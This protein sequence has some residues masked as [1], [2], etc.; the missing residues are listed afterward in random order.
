M[1]HLP[2]SLF[3]LLCVL[4]LAVLPLRADILKGR[5]VDAETKEPLPEASLKL[6][7]TIDYNGRTATMV[8]HSTA[9][10]LGCFHL[11][12]RGRGMLEASMLGYY[13][14][15]KTVLGFSED[16]KDTV[17]VGDIELKPSETL[18]K[19]L[20]VKGRARRFTVRGDTIVFN[21]EAFH[22]QEGAR[23]DELI[24]QLPGVEVAEDGT[25]TWNGKPIRI[26]MD[27]E[28]LFGGDDIV[29]QLPAEAVESIKAYNKA[30]KFSERTGKDDGGE[31]MV[32]DLTIKPG[33]LDRWYGD[34]TAEYQ[35]PK[36]YDAELSMNRLSKT[37][38]AMFFVDA[39]NVDK[40]HHRSMNGGWSSW[41]N[42]YG[43]GQSAAGG[44]QHNWN[45][46]E[47]KQKLSN[48]YSV[49]GGLSHFD[50]W[51]NT[52]IETENFLEEADVKRTYTEKYNRNHDLSPNLSTYF[53]WDPDTLNTFHFEANAD[54]SRKRSN[55]HTDTEQ[56][57]LLRQ[58]TR[59]NGEGHEV[60]FSSEGTWYHFMKGDAE[61]GAS[62]KISYT[63]SEDEQWTER[64]IRPERPTLD[65][66][67]EGGEL[68]GAQ[69][70]SDSE[71]LPLKGERGEGLLPSLT[72][73]GGG[74]S[75]T[76]YSRT[77]STA[78][79]LSAEGHYKQWL[80]KRWLLGTTY[81]FSYKR[82]RSRQH[83]ET[84]GTADA[85]N[86]YRDHNNLLS[87]GLN[88]SSTVDLSPVKIMPSLKA[89]WQR[90]H[91]D[92]Q[93]GQLDTTATRRR[94]LLTPS[95]RMTWKMAKTIGLELNY[96]HATTQPSLISTLAYRDLTDPLYITEGN[97]RLRDTHTHNA[98][99]NFNTV[100][101]RQQLSLSFSADYKQSDRETRTALTYQPTTGIYTS[102]PENVRGTQAWTFRLNYDQGLGE[103]V[104]LQNDLS[105]TTEQSYALLTQ[106][107]ASTP[108][109]PSLQLP[110]YGSPPPASDGSVIASP[111][112]L[113]GGGDGSSSLN[114]RRQLRL[115]ERL[116]V[117]A[118]WSWL[119][120]S[121][122]G[123]LSPNRLRFSVSDEQNT[124]LWQNRF[125][126]RGEAT[127]RQ[128]VFESSLTE[129]MYDGYT[130]A[131]MNRNL[132]V[133]DASATWKFLKNKARLKLELN[134]I[135]NAKDG[136][137]ISQSAYQQTVTRRDF[138]HHY[139]S[140]SFT[141]HLDAKTKE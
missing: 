123:E 3:L 82:N 138:R 133:W 110:F 71:A 89:Y 112:P 67:R 12:L 22:L 122:F 105:L 51:N 33:F 68:A 124:T 86:S 128:F 84:D 96:S 48:H 92:Y 13:S 46:E 94:L 5:I 141:Y 28:S 39:N 103:I 40:Q 131:S 29:S 140:L 125:G 65:P 73:G 107:L 25:M 101:A 76:Q 88:L 79:S 57:G 20:E 56:E 118:D 98:R 119:K 83:F 135:L 64:E 50:R 80:A 31:D 9:D 106:I 27:G 120:L 49:S 85:A 117:S 126:L 44:Y 127:W 1:S 121:A 11:N 132:L 97:P 77:P 36:H 109:V 70:S 93:R 91:Q 74:G 32:L 102:R 111:L 75:F 21:P 54:F 115:T 8:M 14:K 66:S 69:L 108:A 37:D 81:E 16:R 23:L 116:T 95:V 43:Q 78:F 7:Q 113:D 63:N 104:R 38:P 87:H 47:G 17:D 134:D 2:R 26:T 53:I 52:R 114:R 19:M 18:M 55:G 61:L 41:S 58:L 4:L 136:K 24:R 35:T 15:T 130:I 45:R 10:S 62:Y 34:A 72:G 42:G 139:I 129:Q 100:L 137:Y 59:R 90:E 6:A 99:L 30:S 60:R